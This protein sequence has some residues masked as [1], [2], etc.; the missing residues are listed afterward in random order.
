MIQ[1]RVLYPPDKQYPTAF[2]VW[3]LAELPTLDHNRLLLYLTC[4]YCVYGSLAYCRAHR[5]YS[6]IRLLKQ[7][8]IA[9]SYHVQLDAVIVERPLYQ[10][11]L[12]G[13]VDCS[14]YLP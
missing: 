13:V 5:E 4:I 14:S 12:G 6:F 10:R 2:L 7:F 9:I 3:K 1:T 11:R 8:S